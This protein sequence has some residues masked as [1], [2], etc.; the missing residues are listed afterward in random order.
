MTHAYLDRLPAVDERLVTTWPPQASA[1]DAS[2][3]AAV[4]APASGAAAKGE[5]Q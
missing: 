2:P 3:V 5:S 1:I 4:G